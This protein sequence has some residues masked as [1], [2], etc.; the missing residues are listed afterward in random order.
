ME[1]GQRG[2]SQGVVDGR[3]GCCYEVHHDDHRPGDQ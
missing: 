1:G 2:R 3:V